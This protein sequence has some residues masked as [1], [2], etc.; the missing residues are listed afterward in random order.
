MNAKLKPGYL[1]YRSKGIVEHAGV[2]LGSQR[3]LHNS[4]TNGTEVIDYIK[5][6]EGKAVKV[7]ETGDHNHAELAARLE[8]ILQERGEYQASFNNCEHIAHFLVYGRKFSPQIQATLICS[9]IAGFISWKTQK[10][11]PLVVATL[12]GL[13]G[14][15]LNNMTRSYDSSISSLPGSPA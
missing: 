7:I 12:G 8:Q 6:A 13:G 3:V 1:L 15:L 14:C 11:N 5:Y 10:G 4:P 2:Y 9:V